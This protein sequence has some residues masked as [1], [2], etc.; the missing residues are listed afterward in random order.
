MNLYQIGGIV[1]T[2]LVAVISYFIFTKAKSNKIAQLTPAPKIKNKKFK[3]LTELSKAISVRQPYAELIMMGL[4]TEEYRSIPTN[5]RGRIYIY[6]SNTLEK[7]LDG[8]EQTKKSADELPRGV[9]IGTVEIKDCI[10]SKAEGFAWQLENPMR[11]PQV[12][13]PKNKPQ[14]VWFNPF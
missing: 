3:I 11:L 5:I 2:V 13:K 8:I 7:D 10:G 12:L 14:P 1:F 6:A 9:L 4:K